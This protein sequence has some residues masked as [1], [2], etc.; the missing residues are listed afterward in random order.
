MFCKVVLL[1]VFALHGDIAGSLDVFHIRANL[2]EHD[3]DSRTRPAMMD[4]LS[5]A[6]GN[7]DLNRRARLLHRSKDQGLGV[8]PLGT[9]TDS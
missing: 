7:L 3:P 9:N 2:F 1:G 6:P 4:A 5:V 8:R